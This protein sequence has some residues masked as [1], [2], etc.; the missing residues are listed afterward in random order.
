MPWPSHLKL[1]PNVPFDP[2]DIG[3]IERAIGVRL[4]AQ[5]LAFLEETKG[6][7]YVEDLLAE[8]AEP[9][10]FGKSNIVEV[11]GLKGIIRLLDS[12]ITPRNMICIGHGQTTCISVA[13][14]DHGCVY[15]LDTEMRYFWTKETLEKYPKLDPSI[16]NFFRMRENDELPERPWGYEN[17][18]L[19]AESFDKYLNKLHPA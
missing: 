1:E 14:I 7:G 9:T 5:F 17:C 3:K 8:C 18:Y 2:L 12:D 13:G 4:P 15:A 10:P 19:I 16:K 6:G 11:G